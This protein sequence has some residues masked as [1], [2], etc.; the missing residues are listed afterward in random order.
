M[1]FEQSDIMDILQMGLGVYPPLQAPVD[2]WVVH[3]I[4]QNDQMLHASCFG[5]HGV[6]SCLSA[7]FKPSF[8]LS[9]PGRDH[10]R[11]THLLS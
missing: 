1:Q 3:F 11:V 4:H 5:Q 9:F 6:L 8:K 2:C 7:L 10:L